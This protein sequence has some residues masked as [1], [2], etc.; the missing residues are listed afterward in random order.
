M[1]GQYADLTKILSCATSKNSFQQQ[2]EWQ[3]EGFEKCPDVLTPI[4]AR[5]SEQ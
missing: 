4:L 5:H 2:G 3:C 1:A